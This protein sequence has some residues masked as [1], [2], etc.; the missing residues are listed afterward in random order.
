MLKK[1]K[2]KICKIYARFKAPKIYPDKFNINISDLL[3]KP[4]SLKIAIIDDEEFIYKDA[5]QSKGHKVVQFDSYFEKKGKRE[6]LT[7]I[8][9]AKFDVILCDIN[10]VDAGVYSGSDGLSVM[11][12]IREKY[13][14]HVVAAY[15][16]SPGSIYRESFKSELLDK[17]FSREWDVED[18]LLNLQRLA[19]IFIKPKDRWSFIKRRLCYLGVDE[20]KI[21]KVRVVFSEN[22]IYSK[23]LNE[24]FKFSVEESY[25]SII[26][27][28]SRVD[29]SELTNHGIT[30]IKIGSLLKPVFTGVP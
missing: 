14:L 11:K 19:D 5:V 23:M 16:G 12:D 20:G 13:P 6:S 30:A 18:F 9:L 17:V 4:V 3:A 8:D 25:N 10:G 26:D 15:T 21:D 27:S 7:P 28:E 1:I 24:K 2:K 22:I 29:I